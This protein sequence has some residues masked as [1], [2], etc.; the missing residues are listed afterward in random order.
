M[1]Q[2]NLSEYLN[3]MRK[4]TKPQ[5]YASLEQSFNYITPVY[6][7]GEEPDLGTPFFFNE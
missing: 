1:S 2:T 6:R 4:N 5:A 3:A 7:L